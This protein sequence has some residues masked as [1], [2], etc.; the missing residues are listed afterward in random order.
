MDKLDQA[1][2]KLEYAIDHFPLGASSPENY[3]SYEEQIADVRNSLKWINAREITLRALIDSNSTEDLPEGDLNQALDELNERTSNLLINKNTLQLG[4]HS[5]AIQDVV[6]G[7][8]GTEEVQLRMKAC[9][10]KLFLK[11]DELAMQYEKKKE[12]MKKEYELQLECHK[13]IYDHQEFLKERENKRNQEL[14]ENNPDLMT[15][16]DKILRSIFKIHT[17]KKLITNLIGSMCHKLQNHPELV[18]L[19]AKHKDVINLETIVE[20]THSKSSTDSS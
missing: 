13:A 12:L 15:V 4:Y 10:N 17:Q 2:T 9:L 7:G 11:N 20:M 6:Y 5:K 8:A 16:R 1:L 3:K 14:Q 18:D 19:L